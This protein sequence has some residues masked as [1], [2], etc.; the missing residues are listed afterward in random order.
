MNMADLRN[1]ESFTSS[2]APRPRV[3]LEIREEDGD[4][5]AGERL[6]VFVPN[7]ARRRRSVSGTIKKSMVSGEKADTLS[8]EQCRLRLATL[9]TPPSAGELAAE[10]DERRFVIDPEARWYLAWVATVSALAAYS[11]SVVAYQLA[12]FDS[13]RGLDGLLVIEWLIDAVFVVDM[14]MTFFVGFFEADVK[15]MVRSL[16]RRHYAWTLRCALDAT[17]ALP[18]DLIQ[19]GVGWTPFSRANK[20]VRLYSLAHHMKVL[21]GVSHQPAIINAFM[22]V[23]LVL[24]WLLFPHLFA[25]LRILLMR[26]TEFDGEQGRWKEIQLQGTSQANPIVDET[27]WVRYLHALYWC[28][29]LMTGFGDGNIPENSLQHAYT[30]ALINLGLFTFAY[31]VGVLGA[32]GAAGSQRAND[33]QVRTDANRLS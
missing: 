9:N 30:L 5:F 16:C 31:T 14:L 8:P 11:S 19:M 22:I 24:I 28:L 17:A 6:E 25:C 12:F 33:F 21:Q 23:R 20:L 13:F 32:I 15:V 26:Y 27:D 3:S 1:D 7:G 10:R 18:L 2:W 29:G 4:V